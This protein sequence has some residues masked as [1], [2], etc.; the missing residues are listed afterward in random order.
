M[1]K[2]A[3]Q[4]IFQST[5]GSFHP[6]KALCDVQD[7]E[8]SRALKGH[9]KAP[10]EKVRSLVRAKR[11]ALSMR[12]VP[13][14]AEIKAW[15]LHQFEKIGGSDGALDQSARG[16][17]DRIESIMDRLGRYGATD[18]LAE[19]LS[20]AHSTV[21]RAQSLRL[22][23]DLHLETEVVS[24]CELMGEDLIGGRHNELYARLGAQRNPSAAALLRAIANHRKGE[25][26][27]Y[28][29]IAAYLKVGGD[30]TELH[31]IPCVETAQGLKTPTEVFILG[32]TNYWG[33]WKTRAVVGSPERAKNLEVLGALGPV[34]NSANSQGFF[35]WLAAQAQGTLISHLRFI[36]KHWSDGHD[37]PLR[38]WREN[39]DVPCLPIISGGVLRLVTRDHVERGNVF[40]P[41]FP[42]LHE[43]VAS[44][45][46]R[47]GIVDEALT[48][49]FAALRRADV[50]SLREALSGLAQIEP[51]E[52]NGRADD[53]QQQNLELLREGLHNRRLFL[54][55]D[56]LGIERSQTIREATA[57]LAS[58]KEVR[59]AK[60]VLARYQLGSEIYEAEGRS[61]I[62]R[63]GVVWLAA[64]A[65]DEMSLFEAIA[66]RI[67]RTGDDSLPY[68][69]FRAAIALKSGDGPLRRDGEGRLG[70]Q[71]Q[72]PRAAISP[73]LLSS[74][75][76]DDR[77][78]ARS[79]LKVGHTPP[80]L[81][82]PVVP[83][84][85]E[86][87]AV[88]PEDFELSGKLSSY[89]PRRGPTIP[90][91]N[92]TAARRNALLE[93]REKTEL[94]EKH[95]GYHC[96]A[97]LGAHQPAALTP[98]FTYLWHP[99]F[100]EM[101]VQAHHVTH[102]QNEGALGA[103]N[104]LVLCDF[105]HHFLGDKLDRDVLLASLAEAKDERRHFA[106]E[107][108]GAKRTTVPGKIVT[109]EIDEWPFKVKLFFTL[110][111]LQVWLDRAR[112][113][114]DT[115]SQ[116]R[117]VMSIRTDAE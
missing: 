95:Y 92:S 48:G 32:K 117:S 77:M 83:D 105:H 59:C 97:C 89:V 38:W 4:P 54:E 114:F 67:F 17:L 29:R 58:L 110:P 1:S 99:D 24:A 88:E 44:R 93:I 104:L 49:A 52:P 53:R 5:D 116:E 113:E 63:D 31:R 82:D 12:T 62:D 28:R 50:R 57:F 65:V 30:P 86:F 40:L 91:A 46:R 7:P 85:E 37:G 115:N 76:D 47:R 87:P 35:R 33:A 2:I 9:F 6:L 43:Q 102:L 13:S 39:R 22:V 10:T 56:R 34:L 78:V 19:M 71:W 66:D 112:E 100:R 3:E 72:E 15:Y 8:L 68:T 55:L 20:W 111:H 74:A 107:R 14:P 36:A 108:D 69:L 51:I 96:Q 109:L 103:G 61:G 18:I 11:K 26:V 90:A 73:N 41:D 98:S 94:K 23:R 79:G 45:D 21:T 25:A 16:A 64:N 106:L 60:K 80:R 42:G 70:E 75:T 101:R 27:F 81:A 84:P